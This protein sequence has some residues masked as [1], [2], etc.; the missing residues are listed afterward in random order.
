MNN[1]S[2]QHPNFET[3][4]LGCMD[5]Y[6]S[7]KRRILFQSKFA[8]SLS[9]FEQLCWS[10][11][12]DKNVFLPRH[13]VCV[14]RC[15]KKT[16]S[17]EISLQIQKINR[18]LPRIVGI[19][20]ILYSMQLKYS[21][22]SLAQ[23][24]RWPC[25]TCRPGPP[26]ISTKRCGPVPGLPWIRV[27]DRSLFSLIFFP[28]RLRVERTSRK[29]TKRKEEALLELKWRLLNQTPSYLKRAQLVAKLCCLAHTGTS[30][31]V[32]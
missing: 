15:L 21:I 4:V 31:I 29:R 22:Q 28:Q 16:T 6:D 7:V 11:F 1:E 12:G 18:K 20:D 32:E 24:R 13:H 30:W 2:V 23:V 25:S 26:S 5:N 14:P 27:A 3:F 19:S 17:V 8:I 10:G 9:K